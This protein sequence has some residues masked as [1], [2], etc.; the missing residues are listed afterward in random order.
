MANQHLHATMVGIPVVDIRHQECNMFQ[1]QDAKPL[2]PSTAAVIAAEME[3]G[4][5]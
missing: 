5:T 4:L 3:A 1:L 2:P